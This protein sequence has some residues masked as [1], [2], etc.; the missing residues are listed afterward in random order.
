M[1]IASRLS[2]PARASLP[3]RVSPAARA[4]PAARVSPETEVNRTSL[5]MPYG[6]PRDAVDAECRTV[7]VDG[8]LHIRV[9]AMGQRDAPAVLCLH[10]WACSVYSWRHLLPALAADGYRAYALDFPGHGGSSKPDASSAYTLDTFVRTVS[11]VMDQLGMV[12]A[13]AIVAHSMGAPVAVRL[14][15]EGRALGLALFAPIGVVPVP[16]LR[17]AQAATPA[18]LARWLPRLV[19]A[20][21]PRLVLRLAVAQGNYRGLGSEVADAYWSPS[22]DPRF[23]RALRHLLHEFDWKPLA[24]RAWPG[25]SIPVAILLGSADRLVPAGRAV[26]RLGREMPGA[27]VQVLARCGHVIPEEQPA[28]VAVAVREVLRRVRTAP[29]TDGLLP[30]AG[31]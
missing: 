7:D 27:D 11:R 19:P 8:V 16:K 28:R 1:S 31:A 18:V 12:R 25:D 13:A 20:F 21:A 9:V 3:A 14:A 22:S 17:L 6:Y 30:G 29:G 2:L 23:V 10:G 26:A 15:G 24:E 5:D 4:S